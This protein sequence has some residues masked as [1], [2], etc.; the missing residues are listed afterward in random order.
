MSALAHSQR[1]PN[2]GTDIVDAVVKG[3]SQTAVS[4][5]DAKRA[6]IHDD[7]NGIDRGVL[8][9]NIA[10]PGVPAGVC[11]T[12]TV[13]CGLILCQV[14]EVFGRPSPD[15]LFAVLGGSAQGFY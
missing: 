3:A 12:A 1:P 6:V 13:H 4:I 8:G 5:P 10:D 7:E 14:P 15:G 2:Q 11:G 9:P